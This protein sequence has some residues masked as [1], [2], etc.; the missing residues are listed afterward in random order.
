MAYQKGRG[1]ALC[2]A[3]GL[4]AAEQLDDLGFQWSADQKKAFDSGRHVTI[5]QIMQKEA[6]AGEFH[7]QYLKGRNYRFQ[8]KLGFRDFP[9]GRG[10]APGG[11]LSPL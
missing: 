10:F 11:G 2:V 8:G 3:I 4:D 7:Y 9:M 1:T 6:G 5:C